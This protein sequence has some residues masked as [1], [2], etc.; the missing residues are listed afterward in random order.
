MAASRRPAGNL[1]SVAVLAILAATLSDEQFES[2]GWRVPFLLSALLVLF[3]LWIRVS[4][5]ESPVFKAA[6]A[7]AE[8]LE[9]ENKREK[10]PILQIL[11]NYRARCWSRWALASPRTSRTTS[12][13]RSSSP[14]SRST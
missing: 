13:L 3:G 2:W 8:A 7:E 5:S 9:A 4:I 11:A 10:A 6:Q 14:T 1:L 12:S